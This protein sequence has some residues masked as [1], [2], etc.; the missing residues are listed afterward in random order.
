[1]GYESPRI[2]ATPFTAKRLYQALENQRISKDLWPEV[3][4]VAPV[5]EITEGKVKV[6]PFS[7]SHSTPQSVGF[8]IETPEGNVLQPGDFKLDQTLSWGPGF[9]ESQFKNIV[10]NGVDLWLLDSTG[11]DKDTEPCDRRK[12]TRNIV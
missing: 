7:V 12:C 11:A 3:T 9:N 10:K 6:T 2:Y 4:E 1:M 5:Q 8:Y